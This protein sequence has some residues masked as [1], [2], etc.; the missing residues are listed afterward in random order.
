[1]ESQFRTNEDIIRAAKRNMDQAGWDYL[2]GGTETETTMRRNRLSFDKKGFRP[3]ILVDVSKLDTSVNLLGHPL[4]IPVVLA[5]IGGLTRIHPSGPVEAAK[6]ANEFGIIQTLSS[7]SGTELETVA[8]E[9]DN[10]KFFQMYIPGDWGEITTLIDRVKKANFK[11]LAVTVDNARY[12]LRERPL[13]YGTNPPG[14][15]PKNPGPGAS[16]TWELMD[17]I[18]DYSGLPFM[19]KG[20]AT[21][22][23]A[24][25]AIDHE[26][27][28]IWVSNHGGRGLDHGMG[29]LDMLEAIAPEVNGKA[30]LIVDGSILRGSDVIKAVALGADAVTI[31]KLQGW[32]LAAGGAEGLVRTL[33]I[34]EE[35][36]IS[37][38]ALLGV[39][40]VDQLNESYIT[41]A[42]PVVPPHEYSTWVNMPEGRML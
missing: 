2:V 4:K 33:D 32:G 24:N 13:K 14:L 39:T 25:I 6:A 30:E 31:G 22:E 3:R 35:E 10:T 21:P 20:I 23:D 12:S 34:L 11:G 17:R 16:A 8:E 5:P 26:V 42:E 38:M 40:Q 19:V 28:V 41:L 27:D 29:T 36:I 7:V 15:G 18:R 1:M 37:A 9:N